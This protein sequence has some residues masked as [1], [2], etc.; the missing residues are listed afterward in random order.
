L[1][2]LTASIYHTQY[3]CSS[4]VRALNRYLGGYGFESCRRLRFFSLSHARGNISCLSSIHRAANL[5]TFIYRITQKANKYQPCFFH[6]T[7]LNRITVSLLTS[8][9]LSLCTPAK[10]NASLRKPCLSVRSMDAITARHSCHTLF[11]FPRFSGS[12]GVELSWD[13]DPDLDWAAFEINSKFGLMCYYSRFS[14]KRPPRK[15]EKVVIT[16]AGRLQK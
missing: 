9:S 4:F 3:T 11:Q 7:S 1:G 15:L 13:W 10:S 12:E 14:R 5:P 2:V 8:A 6:K 16:R